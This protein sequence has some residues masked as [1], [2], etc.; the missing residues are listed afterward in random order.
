MKLPIEPFRCALCSSFWIG[1]VTLAL[2]HYPFLDSIFGG[3]LIAF[4][5]EIQDRKL[6]S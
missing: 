2:L 6:N 5:A 3:A 1:T 4:I